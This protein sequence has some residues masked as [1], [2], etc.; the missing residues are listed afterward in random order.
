MLSQS[1]W[2]SCVL[3]PSSLSSHY[4]AGRALRVDHYLLIYGFFVGHTMRAATERML[5]DAFAWSASM[6]AA[7]IVTG[8]LN[9]SPASSSV[10]AAIREYSLGR[11]SL[12]PPPPLPRMAQNLVTTLWIMPV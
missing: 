11:I 5:H 10:L 8:D 6:K 1:W 4:Q 3:S 12:T 9:D 2:L 7:V